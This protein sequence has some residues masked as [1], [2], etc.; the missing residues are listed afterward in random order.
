MCKCWII[1]LVLIIASFAIGAYFY[2]SMPDQMIF[3]WNAEGLPDGVTDKAI[4]LFSI[5]VLLLLFGLLFLVLPKIDP[6]KENYARFRKQYD[7]FVLV[8]SAF[9]LYL[10]LAVIVFN[11]G[12]FFNMGIVLAPAFFVLFYYVGILLDHA[13]RNWF[14]GIGTPWTISSDVVW[15]KTHKLGAKT[16]KACAILI[17]LGVLFDQFLWFFVLVPLIAGTGHLVLFSYF[18][19]KKL[20]KKSPKKK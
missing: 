11:L 15:D 10:Q 19:Y 16:F 2:G 20:E 3:H 12:F 1:T 14:I 7:L 5:P 8:I 13:K 18:E 17:L 4:A 9:F 6:L